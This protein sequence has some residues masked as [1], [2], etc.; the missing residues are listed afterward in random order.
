MKKTRQQF[1][2]GLTL[3]E[4]IMGV[5]ASLIVILTVAILIVASHRNWNEA[6]KYANGDVQVNAIETMI[7]FGV[8]GRKANKSDYKLYDSGTGSYV[9][10]VP[11]SNPEEVVFGNAVEFRYWDSEL[12]DTFMDTDITGN[13]YA[14]Y[15]IED[16]EL[17]VDYGPYPSSV[18]PDGTKYGGINSSG[19]KIKPASTRILAKNVQSVTFSHLTT[20][21]EGDG[22]G[23]VKMDLAL[24]DSAE[25]EGLHVKTATLMRNVWP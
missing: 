25:D 6:Y 21:L 19:K 3:V 15:Y 20:N 24:Y 9:T 8:F 4:L 22:N 17:K 16:D 12:N 2:K 5:A 11:S 13:K 10:V 7:N 1:R 14:L 18:A 23:C